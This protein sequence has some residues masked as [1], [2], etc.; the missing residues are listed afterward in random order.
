MTYQQLAMSRVRAVEHGRAVV[1]AATSGVSAIIAPDGAVT[2]QTD[3]FVPA[4]LVAKVP[5]STSS[6]LA[7]RVG[8]VPEIV[9]SII[10]V[11][12]I[13]MAVLARRRDQAEHSPE[14]TAAIRAEHRILG[15]PMFRGAPTRV[16][17]VPP[18]P[19]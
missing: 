4:A 6:T 5:L 2:S 10:A 15:L 8:P 14:E 11:G 19:A 3:L 16:L 1:V 9:L 17:A 7:S 12:A 13:A 18:V